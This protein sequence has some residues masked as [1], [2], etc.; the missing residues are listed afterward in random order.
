MNQTE[1]PNDR[2]AGTTHPTQAQHR[3]PRRNGDLRGSALS[4]VALGL[5]TLGSLAA[6]SGCVVSIGNER[7]YRVVEPTP[8]QRIYLTSAERDTL[9]Q[10]TTLADIPTFS[11]KYASSLQNMNPGTSQEEFLRAFPEAQFMERRT[12]DGVTI[13][14][15]RVRTQE[16]FRYRQN[17]YGYEATYIGWFFFQDGRLLKWRDTEQWP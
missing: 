4:L 5:V 9:P 6:L 13:D 14:A 3:R 7:E 8:T 2:Y 17:A 11:S 15:Y 12:R 10:L 1:Q 16:K